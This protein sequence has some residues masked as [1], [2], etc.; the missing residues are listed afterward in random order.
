MG[1]FPQAL[2]PL[3]LISPIDNVERT[4]DGRRSLSR[5]RAPGHGRRIVLAEDPNVPFHVAPPDNAWLHHVEIGFGQIECD[6]IARGIFPSVRH[7][8]H[9]ALSEPTARRPRNAIPSRGEVALSVVLNRTSL[10]YH[11]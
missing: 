5:V 8:V 9:N 2:T 10:A 11:K 3:A 6:V 7:W 1:T 4:V